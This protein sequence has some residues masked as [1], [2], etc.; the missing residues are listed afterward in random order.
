M[1]TSQAIREATREAAAMRRIVSVVEIDAPA[2]GREAFPC[3]PEWLAGLADDNPIFRRGAFLVGDAYPDG[4]F[5]T[6]W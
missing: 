2:G 3:R 5:Y 4:S 6:E 1:T